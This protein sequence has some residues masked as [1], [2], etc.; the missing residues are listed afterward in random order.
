MNAG[1][2]TKTERG[3]NKSTSQMSCKHQTEVQTGTEAERGS[4]VTSQPSKAQQ[5]V[6]PGDDLEGQRAIFKTELLREELTKQFQL[7]G[8]TAAA[9]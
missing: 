4:R 9:W 6:D 2:A 1:K 8:N 5:V 3:S 7:K